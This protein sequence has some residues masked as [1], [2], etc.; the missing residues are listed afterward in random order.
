MLSCQKNIW[1]KKLGFDRAKLFEPHLEKSLRYDTVPTP[2]HYQHNA[3][4]LG[5]SSFFFIQLNTLLNTW[6]LKKFLFLCRFLYFKQRS[7][8]N[9]LKQSLIG[10]EKDSNLFKANYSGFLFEC[11]CLNCCAAN[12]M[13][14]S[15]DGRHLQ[16]TNREIKNQR[17]VK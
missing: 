9:K 16:Y 4:T 5:V 3:V 2:S 13:S 14:R 11:Y 17:L 12:Y 7:Y 8:F 10:L 6:W 15:L 1:L